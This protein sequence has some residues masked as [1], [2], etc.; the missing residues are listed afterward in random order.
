MKSKKAAV[1]IYCSINA[2][3]DRPMRRPVLLFAHGLGDNGQFSEVQSFLT[4]D[5]VAHPWEN[6][7]SQKKNAQFNHPDAI[8]ETKCT[9]RMFF[10]SSFPGGNRSFSLCVSL[11]LAIEGLNNQSL[12]I[13]LRPAGLLDAAIM[14]C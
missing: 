1:V 9:R 4:K 11:R 14:A 8:N 3:R 5:R 10:S 13:I 2:L 7:T 12:Y 6:E